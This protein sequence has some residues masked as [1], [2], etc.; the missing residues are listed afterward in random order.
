MHIAPAG[1][2]IDIHLPSGEAE[3]G[4]APAEQADRGRARRYPR[5]ISSMR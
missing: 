4:R 5:S 1:G 3:R 2:A